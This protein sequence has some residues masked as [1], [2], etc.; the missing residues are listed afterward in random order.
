[1]ALKS[2]SKVDSKRSPKTGSGPWIALP[3]SVRAGQKSITDHPSRKP[4]LPKALNARTT[5]K[6]NGATSM[7]QIAD[8]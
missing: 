5:A 4:A 3:N 7:L 2:S 6:L 1:M 8:C